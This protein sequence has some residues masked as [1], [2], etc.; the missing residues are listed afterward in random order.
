MTAAIQPQQNSPFRG[1]LGALDSVSA[2]RG[3]WLP[4]AALC[5]CRQLGGSSGLTWEI[6]SSAVCFVLW[7]R[8]RNWRSN[9]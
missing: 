1:L 7:G 8:Y 6:G 4:R 2:A 9:V 3:P 5:Y